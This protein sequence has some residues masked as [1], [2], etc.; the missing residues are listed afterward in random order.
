MT[1]HHERHGNYP[2]EKGGERDTEEFSEWERESDKRHQLFKAR[3]AAKR[4]QA[5]RE[6]GK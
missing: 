2:D 1:A 3:E 4:A 6:G 5:K